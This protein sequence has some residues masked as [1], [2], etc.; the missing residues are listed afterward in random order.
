M[1]LS[2]YFTSFIKLGLDQEVPRVQIVQGSKYLLP[3]LQKHSKK[4]LLSED[5][6]FEQ[7]A[8][9]L[10]ELAVYI[11]AFYFNC[12]SLLPLTNSP[13]NIANRKAF[14]FKKAKLLSRREYLDNKKYSD[15]ALSF[16]QKLYYLKELG[17]D[18]DVEFLKSISI[19]LK[20][21]KLINDRKEG[22]VISGSE[23]FKLPPSLHREFIEGLSTLVEKFTGRVGMYKDLQARKEFDYQVIITLL[24]EAC[25]PY[26][27]RVIYNADKSRAK[28][29]TDPEALLLAFILVTCGILPTETDYNTNPTKN[30]VRK[31][32]AKA[33]HPELGKIDK[34]NKVKK[35]YD[36]PYIT[37][38]RDKI[39]TEPQGRGV[40]Y[41]DKMAH[42]SL[43]ELA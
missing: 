6:D 3:I 24:K 7:L 22:I 12:L 20:L 35:E 23:N 32:F 14:R 40:F 4:L 10:S 38:I 19:N 16:V 36:R 28:F 27:R 29:P 9:E 33:L 26:F 21:K 18:R 8:E 25:E 13:I 37:Y 2:N 42:Q 11:Q 39:T 31:V 15:K 43:N 1:N 34:R 17:Y 30:G 41:T 5:T